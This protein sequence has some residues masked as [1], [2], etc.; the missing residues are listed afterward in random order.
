MNGADGDVLFDLLRYQYTPYNTM[1]GFCTVC[2]KRSVSLHLSM[3]RVKKSFVSH[4]FFIGGS[5]S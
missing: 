2:T 1:S 3:S 5:T 4:Q